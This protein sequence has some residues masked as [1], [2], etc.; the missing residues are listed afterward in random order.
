MAAPNKFEQTDVLCLFGAEAH[1]A[2]DLFS[3]WL[4]EKEERRLLLLREGDA[5]FER[6]SVDHPKVHFI[7]M[8]ADDEMLKQQLFEFLFQNFSYHSIGGKSSAAAQAFARVE[9]CIQEV[10]LIA[11]DFRD[12]GKKILSNYLAN[13]PALKLARK[14]VALFGRFKGVP[15]VICGASPSLEKDIETIRAWENRG[16]ILAGGSAL[17]VLSSFGVQPD[18]IACID[19]EPPLERFLA[20]TAIEVPFFYQNRVAA[21]IL[22]QVQGPR[23]WV[24]DSGTYPIESWMNEQV[25]IDEAS[26]DGG[27]NVSTFLLALAHAFGCSPIILV[28]MEL[29]SRSERVYAA[30]VDEKISGAFIEALDVDGKTVHTKRDWQAAAAWI[31]EF[32]MQHKE[33]EIVNATRGGLPIKGVQR[34]P[35]QTAFSKSG[36][37]MLDIKGRVHA[38]AIQQPFACLSGAKEVTQ[39]VQESFARCEALACALM[40]LCEKIYPALPSEKGEGALLEVELEEEVAYEHFLEPLWQIWKPLF[41][42]D[43]QVH[44]SYLHKLIF[45]KRV[46]HEQREV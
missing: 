25:G 17:N 8:E 23:F 29:S 28:G 2:L 14:A 39:T 9:S 20:Q 44:S 19:P 4:E 32:A 10:N 18:M 43:S 1:E 5:L 15:A 24:P 6:L 21:E 38:A 27:W 33:A 31:E 13:F 30:G 26:F 40:T 22:R 45:I 42:R 7:S 37:K 11:S 16:L 46:I 41:S 34:M 35:L 12:S 3:S 36:K